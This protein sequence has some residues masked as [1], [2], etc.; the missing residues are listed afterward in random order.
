LLGGARL[1]SSVLL[2]NVVGRFKPFCTSDSADGKD[3]SASYRDLE[4]GQPAGHGAYETKSHV[5]AGLLACERVYVN[6]FGWMARPQVR[7]RDC[8]SDRPRSRQALRKYVGS[9]VALR[10]LGSAVPSRSRSLDDE[11]EPHHCTKQ[12]RC[13][14]P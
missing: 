10:V 13:A 7:I 3:V 4:S 14:R 6:E 12:R 5:G 11:T 9:C 8:D 1:L 2:T